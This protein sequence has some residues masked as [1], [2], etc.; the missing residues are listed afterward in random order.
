MQSN[1]YNIA[2]FTIIFIL[3]I[4]IQYVSTSCKG[5]IELDEYNF[6]KVIKH[7]PITLVKFDIAFPYG[8]KHEA[9]EKFSIEVSLNGNELADFAVCVVG[10]KDYGEKENSKLSE[11]FSV[12]EQ[13]PVIKLFINGITTDGI[14]YPRGKFFR[15]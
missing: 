13:Y 12:G 14:E 4:N 2:L 8:E 3:K 1:F 11:R 15:F 6:D 5:C 9:F 7:F 10:I